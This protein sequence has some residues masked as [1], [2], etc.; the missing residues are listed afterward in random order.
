MLHPF[1]RLA[2]VS[3]AVALIAACGSKSRP[4]PAPTPPS[5]WQ[6]YGPGDFAGGTFT[7]SIPSLA[8]NERLAVLLLNAGGDDRTVVTVSASGT[9]DPA[10]PALAPLALA[11]QAASGTSALGADDGFD[12][13]DVMGGEALVSARREETSAR[14]RDGRLQRA[15][16]VGSTGAPMATT[17][18]AAAP[19]PLPLTRSFCQGQ[20]TSTGGF[21]QTWKSSTLAYQTPHAAFYYT[22]E[23]KPGIDAAVAARTPVAPAGVAPFWGELGTAYEAKILG[24]LNTYFGAESDVDGNGKMIFLLANLGKT[25]SNS[26]VVG[27]FWPGDLV[28]PQ[29]DQVTCPSNT[30]GNTADMLYLIDPGNFT[31]NWA[32]RGTYADVLN[33]IL[34]GEYPSTM[35]HEL[36]HDVNYTAH[37]CLTNWSCLDEEL[38]LNEG[39]SMLSETVAGYG[40]HTAVGRYNVLKYQSLYPAY[41]LTTWEADPY[42]NYAGVQAYMQYLL[43]HASPAMT[44]A[45]ENPSVAGKANV[46]AATGVPWDL[47]FARFATAAMFSNEDASATPSGSVTSSG[48]VL[49]DPLYNYL[50]DGVATDYIPWHHYTGSCTTSGVTTPKA[51]DAYVAWTP[52]A[53]SASVA[54]RTDGWSALATGPGSGGAATV[55][56]TSTA[57]VMPQVVVVKYSGKMPNYLAPTCP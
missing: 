13:T 30:V 22:D 43:D 10:L 23:V 9:G 28:L 36:Q 18:A 55:T 26:F 6:L 34:V 3:V 50:G 15:R 49:A 1:A 39:L 21:I 12:R 16:L 19:L 31:A 25:G 54:L 45:L 32:A 38:W 42:G 52:L 5:T 41:S 47:G 44:M 17:A 37:G 24:K 48:N 33:L 8:A 2:A 27:Y 57:S 14:L 29:A 56:V 40:L 11:A 51:R 53:P 46:E 20:L 4:A 35:A 7:V